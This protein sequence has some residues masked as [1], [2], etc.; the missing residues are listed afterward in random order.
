MRGNTVIFL[1]FCFCFLLNR[2]PLFHHCTVIRRSSRQH[3]RNFLKKFSFVS[4]NPLPSQSL[5]LLEDIL[6]R[7]NS[8]SAA[9]FVRV[10]PLN[11]FPRIHIP[12]LVKCVSR[13]PVRVICVPG[14]GKHISLGICVQG[15]TITLNT[16]HLDITVICV[17]PTTYPQCLYLH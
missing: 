6:Q 14:Q 7:C 12:I 17:P 16:Y 13:A 5:A 10:P 2:R 1:C 9:R 4:S 8:T 11:A 3:S 15:N